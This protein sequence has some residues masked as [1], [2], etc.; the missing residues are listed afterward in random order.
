VRLT[1]VLTAVFPYLTTLHLEQIVVSDQHL[2]LMLQSQRATARCPSCCQHSRRVHRRSVRTVTDLPCAQYGVR[3]S[4]QT[5]RFRCLTPTCARR[6]FRERFPELVPVYGRRTPRLRARLE[7]L[8]V[9]LGGRPASRLVGRQTIADGVSRTT[10]LRLV[11]AL[12]APLA[13]ATRVLGVDDWAQRRGRTYGTILVDL[14]THRPVDLLPERSATS[15]AA[16]LGTH[17]TPERIA[18]DRGGA[19]ADGARQAAPAAVQIADRFHLAKNL[20]EPVEALLHRHHRVLGEVAR[21]AQAA[22]TT[23]SPP[24][25]EHAVTATDVGVAPTPS[26]LPAP[27]PTRHDIR[28]QQERRARRLDRYTQAQ[29]LHA[30][31]HRLHHIARRL[32][33]AHGTVRRLVHADVFPERQPRAARPSQLA[34][35]EAYLRTRWEAGEHNAARLWR[36]LRAR[37]FSG[38]AIAV[39]RHV[40]SWRSGPAR[41]GRRERRD[42]AGP[43]APPQPLFAPSPRQTRWLLLREAHQRGHVAA[44]NAL[45]DHKRHTGLD[46]PLDDREHRDVAGLLDRSVA[47]RTAQV[48][49]Q[50]FRL[51]LRGGDSVG[52]KRWLQAARDS[53]LPEFCSFVRGVQRDRAAVEA[54]LAYHWSSGQVEGQI[55][56]LK[57]IKRQM[58]GRAQPDL[59]RQRLLHAA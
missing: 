6:T 53:A 57:T 27:A 32:G 52:L 51:L 18:R 13:T 26:P 39:R 38:A 33:L 5:R 31:G 47:I 11:R 44:V 58:Y 15:F 28:L 46:E 55:N 10:L 59:L 35:H 9:A 48:L 8:G 21:E 7:Q 50:E 23:A 54:A 12:P 49:A 16:W 2:T 22:D 34:V 24:A 3:V 14:E 36:E 40:T 37:G 25:T 56:R 1:R 41:V 45:D 20:G 4:V 42:E 43:T 17:P 19:Y 29:A 30:Q